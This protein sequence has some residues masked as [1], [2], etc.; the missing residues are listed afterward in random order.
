LLLFYSTTCE[1][2]EGVKSILLV[3]N[4]SVGEKGGGRGFLLDR[5]L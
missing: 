2:E 5:L 3:G 4:S 1:G